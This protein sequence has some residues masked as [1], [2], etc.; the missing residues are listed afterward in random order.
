MPCTYD[1]IVFK[2]IS[3][4]FPLKMMHIYVRYMFYLNRFPIS[5]YCF[6][7]LPTYGTRFA[8]SSICRLR[9]YMYGMLLLWYHF[10]K[11]KCGSTHRGWDMMTESLQTTF[12]NAFSWLKIIVLTTISLKFVLIGAISIKPD[13]IR[14]EHDG[15]IIPSSDQWVWDETSAAINKP[16]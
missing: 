7:W 11:G 16:N 8:M 6:Y 12:L 13:L 3:F 2:Y 1:L 9:T 5:Y 14:E 10:R 4:K 15:N